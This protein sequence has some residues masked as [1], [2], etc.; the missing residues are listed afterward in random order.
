MNAAIKVESDVDDVARLQILLVHR[1]GNGA[2][3]MSDPDR[4]HVRESGLV[5]AQSHRDADAFDRHA[6]RQKIGQLLVGLHFVKFERRAGRLEA[7]RILEH[8]QERLVLFHH[9]FEIHA[10]ALKVFVM[11]RANVVKEHFRKRRTVPDLLFERQEFRVTRHELKASLN[12]AQC[13]FG[14]PEVCQ[15]LCIMEPSPGIAGFGFDAPTGNVEGFLKSTDVRQRGGE[16]IMPDTA[17]GGRSFGLL[18][19]FDRLCI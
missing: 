1:V 14:L 17:P 8:A 18:E 16:A 2:A 13:C 19:H 3:G 10:V 6:G 7:F 11:F 15:K 4:R 9:L 5:H 12:G